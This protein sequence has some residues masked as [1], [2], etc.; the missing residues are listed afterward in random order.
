MRC[1]KIAKYLREF[2]WEPVIFTADN[3]AYQFLD[4]T[5]EKDVPKGLEIIRVPIVEPINAF[6]FLSG[7]KQNVPVQNIT[8][9]SAKKKRFIDKF[10]MWIRGNFFIPDAR[11]LWIKP[12]VSFLTKYL[13][14]NPVEA[15]FTDGPPH[16]NTVI[17]LQVAKRFKL[18]WLA[19]FQDPWTQVD[20]YKELY[21]GKR[22]DRKHKQL[23]KAVFETAQKITIA[24]PTWKSDLEAIGA[25]NVDVLYY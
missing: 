19:D 4:P 20:Y 12:S 23:E 15:I 22:A 14:E 10:G 11:F 3:A 5:N 6:K 2:G 24:S 9:N 25:K 8:A 17:G 13:E 7:R 18:P 16:T 1:L 21:I